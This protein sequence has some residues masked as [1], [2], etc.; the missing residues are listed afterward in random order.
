MITIDIETKPSTD[1]VV[2]QRI[3]DSIKPPAQYKKPESIEK[4]IKENGE[5]KAQ[6]LI[7]RTALDSSSGTIF[8][9][10]LA[11]DEDNPII[12]KGGEKTILRDF[13]QI[14]RDQA[15]PAMVGALVAPTVAGHNVKG[16]D[17]PFIWHRAII[18]QIQPPPFF[19]LYLR[20]YSDAVYDTMTEWDWKHFISLDNL[21]YSLLGE[22]KSGSGADVKDM[23]AEDIYNYCKQDVVLTR[24]VYKMMTFQH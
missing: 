3:R 10:G 24:Q 13:F 4:W 19:N 22:G 20:R 14:L 12:L 1:D 2:I 23:V 15:D 9:I 7:D 17:L 21:A 11:I 16:F 5:A 6:E 8:C 18:H